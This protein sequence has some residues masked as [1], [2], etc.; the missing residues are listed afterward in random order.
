V[1]EGRNSPSQE[2]GL[3]RELA[4]NNNQSKVISVRES[5]TS[6]GGREGESEGDEVKHRASKKNK[7]GY[8]VKIG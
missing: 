7:E 4:G 5:E 8:W 2:R 3:N 1:E 6:T